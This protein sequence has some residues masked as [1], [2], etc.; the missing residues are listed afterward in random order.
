MKET[1]NHQMMLFPNPIGLG[2]QDQKLYQHDIQ[3]SIHKPI[4]RKRNEN[5]DHFRFHLGMSR[6]SQVPPKL[7]L[8]SLL[9]IFWVAQILSHSVDLVGNL[10]KR[11]NAIFEHV[12]FLFFILLLD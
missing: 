3:K 2:F 1:D 10:D 5:T 6:L 7:L 4:G 9:N 12:T 8:I 11:I